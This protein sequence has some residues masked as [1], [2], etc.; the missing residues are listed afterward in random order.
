MIRTNDPYYDADV[1]Q[2]ELE[3]QYANRPC[4]SDCGEHIRDEYAYNIDGKII[5]RECLEDY[6]ESMVFYD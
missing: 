3:K 4:C 2:D 6:K 5:C 1:W